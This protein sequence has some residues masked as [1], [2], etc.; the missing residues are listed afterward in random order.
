[1]SNWADYLA[2]LHAERAGVA[3]EVLSRSVAG[4]GTPYDWLARAVGSS[5][6]RVL[7][8]GCGSGAV[9]RRLARPER[10]VVGVDLSLT[11]LREAQNRASG[12][13]VQGDALA[14]PIAS[15][16]VDAVTTSM[17]LA[18]IH[19]TGGLLAEVARVLRPGGV[20]VALTPTIRPLS[21]ADIRIGAR[22]AG[23]MHSPPRFPASIELS[24][25]TALR[26]HG[27]RK[28]EDARERYHFTVATRED[29]DQLLN[30]LYL[31][32]TS[33]S[34]IRDA[35]TWLVDEAS[36]VGEVKVPIPIR[37]IVAIA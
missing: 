27:L 5:A 30:A 23:L 3:E 36:R 20:F 21:L 10:T 33:S 34:S 31:P 18:V 35:A 2:D 7:D 14:L 4:T 24:L 1:M 11:E 16:S 32:S 12:P 22:L 17:G 28:V 9:T 15:G 29:A 13:W 19:P 37:R 26:A 8:V 25:G 6:R